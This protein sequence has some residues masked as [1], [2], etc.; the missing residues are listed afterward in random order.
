MLGQ[1]FNAALKVTLIPA[2]ERGSGNTEFIQ[3]ARANR[4]GAT[5]DSVGA[6]ARVNVEVFPC[7]VKQTY[8][9]VA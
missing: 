3:G 7:N 6:R 9:L 1:S 2:I 8:Q 4:A 5:A